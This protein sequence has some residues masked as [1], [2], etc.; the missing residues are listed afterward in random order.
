[1]HDGERQGDIGSRKNV[2]NLA[3]KK[4]S[5]IRQNESCEKNLAG[6]LQDSTA[7]KQTRLSSLEERWI[8]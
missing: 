6:G 4:F 7:T 8:T 1:M 5:A 2:H 3:K